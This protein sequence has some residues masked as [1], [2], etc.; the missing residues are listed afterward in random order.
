M[1]QQMLT[2]GHM[3]LGLGYYI[4]QQ[5]LGLVLL[6]LVLNLDDLDLPGRSVDMLYD[7]HLMFHGN[8]WPSLCKNSPMPWLQIFSQVLK[9]VVG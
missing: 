8:N 3:D 5:P 9:K 6:Q 4:G 7:L 2:V 1:E